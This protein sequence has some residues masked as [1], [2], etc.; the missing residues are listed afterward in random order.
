MHERFPIY[1]LRRIESGNYVFLLFG[2]GS[3]D[4]DLG[5]T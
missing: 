3:L 5:S 1:Q 2:V 4:S